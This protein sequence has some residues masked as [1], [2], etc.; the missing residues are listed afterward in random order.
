MPQTMTAPAL[1]VAVPGE[2]PVEQNHGHGRRLTMAFEALDDFP[3]LSASRDRVLRIVGDGPAPSAQLLTAV[4][5]D[6]ALVVA[7][8]RAANALDGLEAG[9]VDS[10]AQATQLL[11]PEGVAAVAAD[12]RT[13]D[14][15]ERHAVWD[16]IPERF[17]LH[18][19]TTQRA[20]A[21]LAA[22]GG[23]PDPDRLLVTALLHD[24]G[25]LVLMHAYAGYPNRVHQ[26]ARTP[27]ERMACERAELGVDHA[28]VGG[29]LA[30][31]WGLPGSVAAVIERHHAIDATG[32]AAFVRLADMLAHYG[33][34][35]IVSP[36]EMLRCAAVVGLDR[37]DLR[38]IMVDLPF[39]QAARLRTIEPCPLS[40]REL[41]VLRHLA[42][43]KVYKQIALALDLSTSTVRTH[44][45]N[46]YGK[47]GAVDRAQAV[48]MANERGWI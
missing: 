10:A 6:V 26:G 31:R 34:G 41:D 29:V 9:R 37:E 18:A 44:L 33:Q 38:A 35:G 15:F 23:F 5:S 11:S 16:V 3:A 47:L 2:S 45:H 39:A 36:Q 25:K 19:L 7:V 48:L 42:E 14:F 13:F 32:E 12:V 40:M 27:E 46:I 28:L 22:E 8:L 43:G 24:L 17:R 21:R 20:A 4:E 1:R 30:R